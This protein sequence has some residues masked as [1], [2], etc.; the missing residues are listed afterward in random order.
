MG[1]VLPVSPLDYRPVTVDE[2][3]RHE[4]AAGDLDDK[5]IE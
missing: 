3:G 5:I 2:I 4:V 1:G